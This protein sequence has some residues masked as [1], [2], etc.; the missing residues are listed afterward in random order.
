MFAGVG[1]IAATLIGPA[2]GQ[3]MVS[4]NGIVGGQARSIRSFEHAWPTDTL[5]VMHSDGLTS[6]WGLEPYPGLA[7]RDPTVVAAVLYRDFQRGNDDTTVVV[8][9][10][11]A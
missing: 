3:G 10:E 6:R 11:A 9:R 8:V 1:N 2:G 4:M 7:Q 5:L